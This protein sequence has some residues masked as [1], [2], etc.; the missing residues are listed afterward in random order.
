M[1]HAF[2]GGIFRVGFFW[3][4][5]NTH[6]C[7]YLTRTDRRVE[8]LV[9]EWV[10]GWGVRNGWIDGRREKVRGVYRFSSL[11]KQNKKAKNYAVFCFTGKK[12]LLFYIYAVI[13]KQIFCK[14]FTNHY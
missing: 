5:L 8:G 9:A 6:H 12:K 4:W 1:T 3:D 10:V 7:S 11:V 13:V 2:D 14:R